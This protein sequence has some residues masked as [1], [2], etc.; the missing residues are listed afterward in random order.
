MKN[1]FLNSPR[2]SDYLESGPCFIS[3]SLG[4]IDHG[5]GLRGKGK[6]RQTYGESTETS[7]KS[8]SGLEA[9]DFL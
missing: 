8:N 3:I 7:G 6:G 2:S 1:I 9:V 4:D 5:V